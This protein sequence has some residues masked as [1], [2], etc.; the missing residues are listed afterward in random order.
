MR[1]YDKARSEL[2]ELLTNNPNLREAQFQLA[3][4]DEV[5][6]NY[7]EA[8]MRFQKAAQGGDPRAFVGLVE[9]KVE[10]GHFPE[11]IQMLS[12]ASDRQ[13][14]NASLRL[15]LANVQERAGRFDDAI[16]N[17]RRILNDN[18]GLPAATK[19]DLYTRIGATERRK[20]DEDAALG[21]FLKARD[22]MPNDVRPEVEIG[23]I[24]D[25][26]GRREMA[27]AEYQKVLK[28]DPENAAA[29][30]NLAYIE[31]DQ[32]TDLDGALALAERARK[33]LPENIDVQDT[34]ALVY[35]RK[36]LTDE[37]LRIMRDVVGRQPNNPTYRYHLALALAQK[38]DKTNARNELKN[39]LTLKPS[40]DDQNRIRELMAR[41][42]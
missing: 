8:E 34:L 29:M 26:T 14:G 17:F 2:E 27:R 20:G 10:Q 32:S 11:A 22:L 38:G 19:A 5:Q 39:A 31:A 13:P 9:S 15:A 42:G 40:R 23:M 25:Q 16:A 12:S 18:S 7:H 4:L 41:L 35:I 6:G 21:S 24:Y 1:E 3:Q 33:K 36:N 28:L 37:G 30:N